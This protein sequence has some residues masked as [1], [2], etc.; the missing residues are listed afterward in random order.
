MRWP[1]TEGTLLGGGGGG[2]LARFLV[3][4]CPRTTKKLTDNPGK[5]FH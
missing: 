5:I 2:Q 3:G 1:T 4:M